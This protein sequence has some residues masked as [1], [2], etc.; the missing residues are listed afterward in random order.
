MSLVTYD[1]WRD[2]EQFRE[3]LSRVFNERL[4]GGSGDDVS[5]IATSVWSPAVDIRE[6]EDR[7]VLHA[8][9]PGVDPND[10][11]ITMEGGV[12]T[13]K[14]ERKHEVSDE[15]KGYSR[16]ERVYGSFY[17]RFGLP[18][19][20]EA[21]KIEAHSRN[22]VLEVVIPKQERAKPRQIPVQG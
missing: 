20:A 11:E 9:V 16:M 2:L 4:P 8:D 1:P 5:S 21:D 12:L 17:R 6:E 14:G 18:N 7:F 13:I 10:I 19:T 3:Q 15:R 22:G